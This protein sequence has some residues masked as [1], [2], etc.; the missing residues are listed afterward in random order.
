MGSLGLGQL[1]EVAR[2]YRK[3]RFA[4][5]VVD[6][7]MGLTMAGIEGPLLG[8]DPPN[9]MGVLDSRQVLDRENRQQV[10]DEDPGSGSFDVRSSMCAR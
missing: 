9:S 1:A 5:S 6:F 8:V 4:S 7:L 2:Q 3:D 10:C